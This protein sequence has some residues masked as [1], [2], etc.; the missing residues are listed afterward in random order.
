[1]PLGIRGEV[2]LGRTWAHPIQNLHDTIAAWNGRDDQYGLETYWKI[3][4]T[5]DL[6]VTPGAQLIFDPSFNPDDDVI[7]I[8]QFKF[9][10]FF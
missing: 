3:L 5:P 6:W 9:R 2:A 4:L 7:A 10:L 8:A 1:M